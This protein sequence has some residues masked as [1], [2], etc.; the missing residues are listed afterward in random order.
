[1]ETVKVTIDWCDRNY[2]A[3]IGEKIGGVV[4]ITDKSLEDLKKKLRGAV[5]AHIEDLGEDAAEWLRRGDY[6]FE[7][8]FTMSATLQNALNYTTLAALSRI[9]GIRHAQLSHYANAVSR[10]KPQ[11]SEKIISG[12]H[13]IGHACLAANC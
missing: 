4:I 8:E 2:S 11:Q 13:A 3:F 10:P 1:M 6:A 12:L 9:T 5:D 7:Y